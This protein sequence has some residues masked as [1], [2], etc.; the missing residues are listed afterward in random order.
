MLENL[1]DRVRFVRTIDLEKR[2]IVTPRNHM[3][4]MQAMIDG[5]V[6]AAI[7]R[8]RDHIVLSREEATDAVRKAYALIYVPDEPTD[9]QSK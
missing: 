9:G 3:D 4:I 1:N 2:M 6:D 5:N 7:D 8:M